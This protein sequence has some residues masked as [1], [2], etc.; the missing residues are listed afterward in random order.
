M[1]DFWWADSKRRPSA[2]KPPSSRCESYLA[3]AKV[4]GA[5]KT[6]ADRADTLFD[7]CFGLQPHH[8]NRIAP[9][10]Y[11]TR[12]PPNQSLSPTPSDAN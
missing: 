7:F 6:D 3:N 5:A 4:N 9:Q 8:R 12:A 11:V 10:R 2:I 1:L